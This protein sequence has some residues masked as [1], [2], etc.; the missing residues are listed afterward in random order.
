MIKIHRPRMWGTWHP[1]SLPVGWVNGAAAV[2]KSLA[3]PHGI[4]QR[5]T[6]RPGNSTPRYPPE[7]SEDMQ[8]CK[9][10]H[11]SVHSGVIYDSPKWKRPECPLTNEWINEL[12]SICT[13]KS[14]SALKG[15]EPHVLHHGGTV[16]M[17]C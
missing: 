5:V 17:R 14:D 1:H 16:K 12:C 2:E 8:S 6:L 9:N 3:A 7:R 11:V 13:V 10:L 4:K 15:R